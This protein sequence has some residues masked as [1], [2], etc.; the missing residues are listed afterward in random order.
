MFVVVENE[1]NPADVGVKYIVFVTTDG[2]ATDCAK[3]LL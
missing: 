2:E 3:A 1:N